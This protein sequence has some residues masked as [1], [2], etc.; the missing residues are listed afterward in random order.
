V[1]DLTDAVP[2]TDMIVNS[3]YSLGWDTDVAMFECFK[4]PIW[5]YWAS[6]M[7]HHRIWKNYL[8]SATDIAAAT[9]RNDHWGIESDWSTGVND[10]VWGEVKDDGNLSHDDLWGNDPW[11]TLSN[12]PAPAPIVPA[13]IVQPQPDLSHFPLPKKNSSQKHGEDFNMFFA[14]RALQNKEKEEKEAP[15]Q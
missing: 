2:H 4:V 8:P 13:S 14:C 11:G 3:A 6:N 12:N 15:S 5:V 10:N 7:V 1:E 9:Q